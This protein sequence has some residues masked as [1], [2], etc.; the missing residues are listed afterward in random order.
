[1]LLTAHH[2][3]RTAVRLTQR[4]SNLR[5]G[6]FTV[7]IQQLGTV[8]DNA[9]VLL[10]CSGKEARYVYQRYDRNIESIAETNETRALAGCI[11]VEYARQIFRLVGYD[12]D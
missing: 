2:D 12:T 6:G 3:V 8:Q 5:Y 9:V 1:M 10:T 4:D 7:G 11:T